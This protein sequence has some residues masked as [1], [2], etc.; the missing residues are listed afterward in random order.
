M[1]LPVQ[2]GVRLC[3]KK[4]GVAVSAVA[5]KWIAVGL[6]VVDHIGAILVPELLMLRLIGRI[7]F[8]IF[9]FLTAESVAHT[10]NL[11]RFLLRLLG[12]ALIAEVP[13][14]LCFPDYSGVYELNNVLF[15][16]LLG[17]LSGLL[18]KKSTDRPWYAALALLPILA[19]QVVGCDYGAYGAG[20]VLLFFALRHTSWGLRG[21]GFSL[22]TLLYYIGTLN[23]TQLYAL[24]AVPLLLVY[25]GT[26]GKV[27][28][29]Y[30]FY[31][32]YPAHLLVLWGLRQIL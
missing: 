20:A 12:F 19:A 8:P 4:E 2:Q 3:E 26:R 24:A 25:D 15:T 6:M 13:F 1:E 29:K 28:M 9:A 30:F 16:L 7:S 22:L 32:F 14:R 18:W 17:S 21:S 27:R 23:W 11:P 31:I 5:L 10:R